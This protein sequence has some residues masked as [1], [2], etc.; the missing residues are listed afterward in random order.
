MSTDSSAALKQ[1]A[2]FDLHIEAGARIVPFAGYEMPVQYP[3]GIMNEHLHTRQNAGLFDVSHMGQII[4]RGAGV[5]SALEQIIPVDIEALAVNQ[6]S[7]ALFT[8]PEGGIEDDLIVTRWGPDEFFLVVNAA[9]K[10][11][12]LAHL[13]ANL[14]GFEID[15]LQG[16]CL[17]ALQGPAAIS[18]MQSL[19]TEA[20]ELVFMHGCHTDINGVKCFVTRSGYTGEDGFEISFAAAS[21]ELVARR[22]LS[23]DQVQWVGLGAR[24]S[25]RLEAGLCLYGHD[26]NASTSPVQASLLWSI[27][28]SRRVDGDKAGGFPGADIIFQQQK[29]GVNRRRVGFIGEGRVPVREG[30]ELVNEHG[31]RVGEITSGGYGPTIE[32]VVAMGYVDNQYAT[33]GTRLNAMVRGKPRPVVVSKMP[34]VEQRYYRG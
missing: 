29:T 17:L 3:A 19:S 4:V 26:M 30:A 10:E 28:K 16:Q 13:Q 20:S 27:S 9:C 33:V 2:F 15:Y 11:Q 1:T 7:Y 6:Q 31:N 24:D 8:N 21:A 14:P 5:A 23:F 25:L 18:V 34:F 22:L 32:G 12:D